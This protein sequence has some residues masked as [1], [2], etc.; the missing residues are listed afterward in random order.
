MAP[1]MVPKW[2][3]EAS[4]ALLGAKLT[5]RSQFKLKINIVWHDFGTLLGAKLDAKMAPKST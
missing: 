2:L 3:L 4:G 5:P 1:K